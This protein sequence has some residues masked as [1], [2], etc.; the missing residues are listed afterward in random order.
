[1]KPFIPVAVGAAVVLLAV[2]LGRQFLPSNSEVGAPTGSPIPSPASSPV[3][4]QF[5]FLPNGEETVVTVDATASGSDLSGTAAVDYVGGS[6]TIGLQCLRQFDDRTWMLAG[7]IAEGQPSGMWIAIMVRDSS[8]QNVGIWSAEE[9][10]A[11]TCEEFV[12][13]IPDNAVEGPEMIAP[14]AEGGVT[15]PD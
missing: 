7:S 9:P 8:P 10:T 1:M 6:F 11:D 12:S 13:E 14:M 5:T 15:L 3:E 2:V 4:G